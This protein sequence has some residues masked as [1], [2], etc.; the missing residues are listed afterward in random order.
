MQLH[1]GRMS[2]RVS[3]SL[4]MIDTDATFDTVYQVYRLGNRVLKFILTSFDYEYKILRILL[5]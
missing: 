4:C 1:L 5:I 2:H 3:Q